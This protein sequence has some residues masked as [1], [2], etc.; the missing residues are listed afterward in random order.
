MSTSYDRP[1]VDVV[2]KLS[3]KVERGVFVPAM[4]LS[5]GK[6][7]LPGKKQIFRKRTKGG[8]YLKDIIGLENEKINGTPLLVNVMQ[9]GRITYDAPQLEEIRRV[10]QRNLSQLPEKYKK[11]AGTALYS[12]E[13][14]PALRKIANQL[15]RQ[16]R[17]Q[18]YSS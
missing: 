9:K 13:L 4:K 16:L 14:S 2:Y 5:K 3:G 11:L 15:E 7:T 12:V 18:G 17:R 1:Y 10:T 6:I 8:K